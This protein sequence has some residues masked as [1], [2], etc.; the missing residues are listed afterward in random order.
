[1]RVKVFQNDLTIHFSKNEDNIV[2]EPCLEGE[3]AC[4]KRPYE[5]EGRYFFMNT[6]VFSSHD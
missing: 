6:C 5:M 2:F 3:N 1:M 4:I